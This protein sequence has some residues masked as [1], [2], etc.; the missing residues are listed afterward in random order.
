MY[1]A[2]DLPDSLKR[3]SHAHTHT[4]THT[5]TY[6]YIIFSV[7]SPKREKHKYFK[8]NRSTKQFVFFKELFIYFILTY[9]AQSHLNGALNE[10]QTHLYLLVEFYIYNVHTYV[11]I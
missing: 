8:M 9:V 2:N 10:T 6:I 3:Y 11:L 1:D 7:D 4:H 5:H